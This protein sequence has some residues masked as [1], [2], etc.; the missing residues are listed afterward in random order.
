MAEI[1]SNN[2]LVAI[3]DYSELAE[4]RNYV[5]NS[6]LEFGLSDKKTNFIVLAVDE[7][8]SNL[9][10][11]NMDFDKSRSLNIHIETDGEKFLVEITDNGEAFNLL[12]NPT[13]EMNEYFRQ[14]KKGGLGIHIIRSI[15]D[16]IDY[17]PS[18]GNQ[19]INSLQLTMHR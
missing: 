9:I 15:V 18:A 7:A 13:P 3:G 12:N 10:R 5:K 8:C 16:E 19:E 1:K 2:T 11:Y 6:A 4:I 17:T 14:Y